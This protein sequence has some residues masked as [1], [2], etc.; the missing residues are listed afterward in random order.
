MKIVKFS[1]AIAA[2][3]L[4]IMGMGSTVYAF[5]TGGVGGCEGCHTMHNS[6]GGTSIIE[7]GTVGANASAYL[8]KAGSSGAQSEACLEC[9]YKTTG[10]TG[11]TSTFC[12]YA[13][14][15]GAQCFS[16]G[17]DFGWL[18]ATV[19]SPSGH[20]I[21]APDFGI[22]PDSRFVGGNAP[23]GSYPYGT[24][25]NFGCQSCHDPHGKA[26]YLTT[27][28]EDNGNTANSQPIWTSGSYGGVP[29]QV[30]GVNYA[31]GVYRILGSTGYAPASLGGAFSFTEPVMRAIAPSSGPSAPE[32]AI[33]GT[34]G[35][36]RVAYGQNTSEWCANCHTNMH[37][38]VG[39]P[40]SVHPTGETV[41]SDIAGNYNRYVKT[42][43]LNGTSATA[44]N[45]LVPFQSDNLGSANDNLW[46]A[47][48]AS[49]RATGAGMGANDRVVC[50]SCHRSHASG[51][52]SM[53]RYLAAGES[54]F[55]T[56]LDSAGTV[57]YST[58]SGRPASQL[59]YQAAMNGRP[60]SVFNGYQRLMCNKC[61]QKD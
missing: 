53:T 31:T 13:T 51:F 57:T 6:L 43:V 8:L 60:A 56:S 24:G 46:Q 35:Q 54:N 40:G 48:L 16:P 18:T 10:S 9:H 33:T 32:S 22:N 4:L 37:S 50:Q 27:G 38:L 49:I 11:T 36:N 47:Q 15:T 26:R 12:S 23:G 17:G 61:H 7:G 20:N 3:A 45:S 19:G 14:G 58:G 34:A 5:H 41:G 39:G 52:A 25:E 29:K 1:F 42:G 55:I 2:A 21:Y 59:E 28:A 30:N 44:F